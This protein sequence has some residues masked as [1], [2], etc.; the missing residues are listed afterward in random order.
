MNKI[1]TEAWSHGT[2]NCQ[3]GW[4]RGEWLKGG[5]GSNQRTYIHDP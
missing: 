2:D 1:E 3:R 4:V 5:E